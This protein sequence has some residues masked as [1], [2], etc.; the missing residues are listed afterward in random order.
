MTN[1]ELPL[2]SIITINYNQA[3]VTCAL[4]KSLEKI[5]YKPV[6]IIVVDNGSAGDDIKNAIQGFPTVKLILT[7]KNLGFA[8]GN[9]VGIKAAK[10]DLVLLINNDVE[11]TP[12][13]L[14]PLVETIRSKP[15]IGFVSPKILFFNSGEII[16]YAG[17]HRMSPYTGRGKRIG[18]LEKDEGQYDKVYKTEFGHGACLMVTRDVITKVG[19]MPEMYFL[20]YE[21]SDWVTQAKKMRF[22]VY[23]VGTS[24]VYHKESISTGKNSPLKTYYMARNRI[25]YINRNTSG[26]QR[27]AALLFY[28]FIASP[29]NLI[30]SLLKG[31]IDN[32]KSY[33]SGLAWHLQKN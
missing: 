23:F 32:F 33:L 16:Q 24:K 18:Y 6:E 1:S 27:F 13:F 26:L 15:A 2:V 3:T 5:S 21:E 25:I 20:Y 11:V 9:N 4:L 8:G 30:L 12:D 22:E 10:G 14:E 19:L 17:S 29:K 7:H 28:L 31:E